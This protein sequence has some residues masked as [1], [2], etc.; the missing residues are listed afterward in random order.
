MKQ[1]KPEK[2]AAAEYAKAATPTD[3]EM[4][5]RRDDVELA[6]VAGAEWQKR[7]AA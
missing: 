1:T 6:F 4:G 3:S 7:E 5:W 2:R